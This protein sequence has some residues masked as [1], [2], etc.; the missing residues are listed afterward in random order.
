MG[1][2]P[3]LRDAVPTEVTR[4]RRF[5]VT[6][7]AGF[8][9][10]RLA[11]TLASRGDEV[12]AVVSPASHRWRLESEPRIS[13]H[14]ADLCDA[15]AL[16]R[17]VR[18]ARPDVIYHLAAH[19][20]YPHQT[21]A[22]RILRTNVLGTELLL[23]TCE[24]QGYELFVSAGSSSEYGS[25]TE[26]MRESDLPEPNSPYAVSKVAQTLL[27]QQRAAAAGLP[28]VVL[29]LFSV[30]GPLEEPTRLVPTL[31]RA[32]LAGTEIAMTSPKTSRDFIHVDDVVAAFLQVDA[33]R[34][35]GGEVL[36]LGTG[37]QSSL[38]DVVAAAER[39]SGKTARCVWNSMAPRS[40]DTTTWVA[41]VTKLR[42]K[43]GFTAP[44]SLVEGLRATFGWL[45]EHHR[46]YPPPPRT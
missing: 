10:A 29:R 15:D 21:D 2:S 17:T 33:L 22:A 26:P 39:A 19:G 41:D 16:T 9:G 38:E 42:E 7:A 27:C 32:I 43:L 8:V 23:R 1:P 45:R 6:G 37:I 12:H 28:I 5:L 34:K 30:Y 4:G 24:A 3:D 20:A 25:K 13:V 14:V 46:E 36:N 40:W 35:L 11:R 31:L 18:E 44:T